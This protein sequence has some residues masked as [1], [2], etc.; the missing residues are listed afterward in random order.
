MSKLILSMDGL[1]LK[2]IP[3]EKERITIGRKPH[4]DIQIDNL[5]ISGDHA[6]ITTI[7][8]DAFLEDRNSTNGTYVNGHPIKRCALR[9]NDLIELGKYR[10][11]YLADRDL[12]AGESLPSPEDRANTRNSTDTA[13]QAP[14]TDSV[15]TATLPKSEEGLIRILSGRNCGRELPLVKSQTTLGKPGG[16]VAII[17]RNSNGYFV[18]QADGAAPPTLNGVPLGGK[19]KRLCNHDLLEVAGVKMEFLMK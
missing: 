11:K 14:S 3:L 9:H 2:E 10:L 17:L 19:I 12:T 15:G 1:V 5:A 8:D 7:L 13:V 6:A 4:N 16:E 18:S